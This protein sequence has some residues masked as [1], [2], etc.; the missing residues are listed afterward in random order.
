MVSSTR[1]DRDFEQHLASDRGGEGTVQSGVDASAFVRQRRTCRVCKSSS[2]DLVLDYGLM[3]LA[4]GFVEVH[5]PSQLWKFPLQLGRCR[6]CTLMMTLQDIDPK[7]LFSQYMYS[8]SSSPA[9]VYHFENLAQVIASRV[10]L[11]GRL[12]IDVGSN[13]GILLRPLRRLG[14]KPLGVDPSDVAKRASE[15]YDLPL[16]NEFL[17]PE[18]A[19]RIRGEYGIPRVI[20]ACNVLAHLPDPHSLVQSLEVL[21]GPETIIFIEV[22]YQGSLLGALQYD[23]VY[24]EHTCYYSLGALKHLLS[25][26]GFEIRNFELVSNHGGSIRVVAGLSKSSRSSFS[27]DQIVEFEKSQY[28]PEFGEKASRMKQALVEEVKYRRAQGRTIYGYGASGRGTI[29]LNWCGFTNEDIPIVVDRSPLRVG[30]VIPGVIIPIRPVDEVSFGDSLGK[31]LLVDPDIFLLTAWNYGPS[32]ISQHPFYRGKWLAP[33]PK[34]GY[35]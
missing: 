11:T 4:G 14:G 24:H 16:V 28:D 29:L 30:K 15:K 31:Y 6:E 17:T 18:V 23:T 19:N 33:L 22:H 20:T 35:V 12:C 32:I 8:S 7:M 34:V 10:D 1:Q 5:D 27:T 2:I 26:H 13:D 25:Q 3:P 9:L 21:S